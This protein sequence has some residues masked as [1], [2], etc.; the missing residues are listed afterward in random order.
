M[1]LGSGSVH[2]LLLSVAALATTALAGYAWRHRDRPGAMPFLGAMVFTAFWALTDVFALTQTFA[3]H[4]VWERVQ[5]LAIALL[6]LLF[7][8]F[9]ADFTGYGV[10]LERRVLPFWF[11][12][13]AIS[14]VLIW[15]NPSHQLMWSNPELVRTGGVVTLTQ[16]FGPWFWVYFLYAYTILIVGFVLLLRLVVVSDYLYLDQTVLII[17]GIV[18]PLLG[19]AI[20][21]FELAPLTGLD[22]TPYGFAITGVAFGNAFLRYRLFDILPATRQLSNQAALA[23]VDDGVVIVGDEK[24]ILYLNR[25]ASDIFGCDRE[26]PFG[27]PLETLLSTDELDFESEDAFA[28]L[29]IGERTY[30]VT[31]APITDQRDLLIGYTI[32]LHDVTSRERR[33]RRLRQQRDELA[34]LEQINHVIRSVNTALVNATTRDEVAET[35]CETLVSNGLYEAAW[36]GSGL[37]G[38]SGT[39]AM[40]AGDDS[41][42]RLDSPEDLPSD[43]TLSGASAD[44]DVPAVADEASAPRPDGGNRTTVPLVHGRT[45]YGALVLR[46]ERDEG[47]SKRERE[48]L[49]ELGETIGR[50]IQAVEH[51]QLLLSD[52]VVE[53]EFRSTDPGDVFVVLSEQAG[54]CTLDGI[55]PGEGGALL[56]YVTVDD[57]TAAEVQR[58]VDAA[59]GVPEA[60]T[61][62]ENGATTVEVSLTSGSLCCPLVEYGA[63]VRSAEATDGECRLVAE[64]SPESDVRS[65]VEH[66]TESFPETELR[67]KRELEPTAEDHA[68][69][70]GDGL[71]DLTDRQQEALEAAFRAGYFEWPRESTA[72]DVAESMDISSATLHNHLRKAEKRLLAE[73]FEE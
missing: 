47:F 66:V 42:R 70:P 14:V 40:T 12:I 41:P 9:M 6:P 57:A 34:Q 61:V 50:A 55:V 62:S 2:V 23:G 45:V 24:E 68:A 31:T 29:V 43:V 4:L 52:A 38:A 1:L 36:F 16:T 27:E 49:G 35:V 20:S 56:A 26:D 33:E 7:F 67:A 39:V 19:N 64:V 10:V 60:R 13:P 53:L 46:T 48:V 11:V 32:L 44:A 8:L 17:V 15:T 18:S 22:L 25:A 54:P 28:E 72:E 21:V 51:R 71:D 58:V 59:S 65:V 63:N 5:W 73:F 69:L 37:S 3:S 30:E